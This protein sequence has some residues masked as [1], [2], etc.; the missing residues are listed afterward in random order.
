[1][2]TDE[3]PMD[4]QVLTLSLNM[5]TKNVTKSMTHGTQNV[6]LLKI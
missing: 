6:K 3:T 4:Y 5:G 2:Q 1:M